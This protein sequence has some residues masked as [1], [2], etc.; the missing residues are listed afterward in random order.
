MD[1]GGKEND[2]DLDFLKAFNY[3][4]GRRNRRRE[5]DWLEVVPALAALFALAYFFVPGFRA[6][7]SGIFFLAIVAAGVA[8][9][10]FIA[11]GIYRISRRPSVPESTPIPLP[12][13]KIVATV[14]EP[15]PGRTWTT[16]FYGE[17]PADARRETLSVELLNKLEWRRFEE[18]VTLYFR[19][20]GFDARRSRVGADGGVDI[21]L[22]RNNEPKPFA[23]VQCKAWHAYKV[24]VKP[25]RELFGVMAA[26]QIPQGYFVTAGMFTSEAAEFAAGKAL[27]LVTGTYLLEKLRALPQA[28]Q[29]EILRRIT[30]GDYTT[31]TCPRCDEKMVMRQGTFGRFWG[32]PNFPRCR[33]KLKL[34]SAD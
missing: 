7:L 5:P 32:C 31:P 10:A 34:R 27:K 23:Y 4:M 33:A 13:D 21:L 6:L 12:G 15:P 11:W 20:T 26:E 8:V 3:E 16:L 22:F 29:D 17:D 28:D 1:F 9:I 2:I 14:V 25:V 24:G 30:A 18:L 19:K